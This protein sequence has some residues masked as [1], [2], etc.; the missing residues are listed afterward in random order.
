MSLTSQLNNPWSPVR[1]FLQ[2]QFPDTQHFVREYNKQGTDVTTILPESK[3][4]SYTGGIIGTAVDYRIP[5]Y[6]GVTSPNE[7]VAWKGMLSVGGPK[8]DLFLDFF[9]SL[10]NV[11][12]Q[13]Q[14]VGRLLERKQ[15]AL[16]ARHCFVLALLEQ[17]FRSSE[18]FLTSPLYRDPPKTTVPELLAIAENWWVNDLCSLSWAFYEERGDLLTQ[19]TIL[20]P[21]FDGSR[22]VG[23]ADADF[24]LDGCLVDI[25]ATINPK[26]TTKMLHQLLGYAL[27]D[28]ADRY[29]IR[30]V[31]IYFARQRKLVRWPLEDLIGTL[32]DGHALP[33][34]ELRSCF[35]SK[36]VRTTGK[37]EF[38]QPSVSNETS[39]GLSWLRAER[40]KLE[41]ELEEKLKACSANTDIDN[42]TAQVEAEVP[43]MS[44]IRRR[45][46][47]YRDTQGWISGAQAAEI[48]GVSAYRIKKLGIYR[49]IWAKREE[50]RTLYYRPHMLKLAENRAILERMIKEAR[51]VETNGSSAPTASV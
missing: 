25:K 2:E 40:I 17:M 19:P 12:D 45:V 21:K 33:L 42:L 39:K 41:G 35:R 48:V 28:Y 37:K 7:L 11:L 29:R 44:T 15:E 32:A 8:Q 27:L 10:T 14:P 6:F 50:N 4:D 26:L 34:N 46:A 13:L 36:I 3:V 24:V 43:R 5:Y 30:E 16:L 22:D 49:K 20:N 31:A 38:P 23:G 47:A 9:A 18:A 51:R 1:Q